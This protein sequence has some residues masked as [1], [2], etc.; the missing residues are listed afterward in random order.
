[1]NKFLKVVL[2]MIFVIIITF[3]FS[4]CHQVHSTDK[5]EFYKNKANGLDIISV[6]D[7]DD[8]TTEILTNR[9]A[10]GK[11]IIERIF[12][13]V[14]NAETGEGRIF[15]NQGDFY[16]NY[17]RVKG[18][19]NGDIIMTLDIYNPDTDYEDDIIDRFDYIIDRE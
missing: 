15:S 12:G 7:T 11:L 14:V 18:I 4:Y 13:E 10:N 19:R 17:S 16:I 5:L 9:R 1:M 6:Y 3:G 8:L 2:I